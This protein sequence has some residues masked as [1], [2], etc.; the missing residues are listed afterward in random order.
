[1][2]SLGDLSLRASSDVHKVN[3]VFEILNI[4]VKKF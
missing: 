1:M 3:F 4:Q 2:E